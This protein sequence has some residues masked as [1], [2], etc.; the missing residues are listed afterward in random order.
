MASRTE[1]TAMRWILKMIEDY[2]VKVASIEDKKKTV[3]SKCEEEIQRA[4]EA[5]RARYAKKVE[6]MDTEQASYQTLINFNIE[7]LKMITGGLTP[8]QFAAMTHEEQMKIVV[9]IPGDEDQDDTE[10]EQPEIDS[11]EEDEVQDTPSE[12]EDEEDA[13]PVEDADTTEF[14]HPSSYDHEDEDEDEDHFSS[15]VDDLPFD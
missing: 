15:S 9:V 3:T 5:I 11:L 12:E 6:N 10:N 8:E 4:A 7:H 1:V 2:R 13:V 14:V